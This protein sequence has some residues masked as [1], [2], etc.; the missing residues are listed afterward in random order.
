MA[1]DGPETGMQRRLAEMD[2]RLR[3]I[4]AELSRDVGTPER[5][6]PGTRPRR[7]QRAPRI[8]PPQHPVDPPVDPATAT[9]TPPP[10]ESEPGTGAEPSE[11]ATGVPAPGGDAARAARLEAMCARLMRATQELLSGYELAL[12]HVSGG[13]EGSAVTLA[14]GPFSGVA[15]LE[16]FQATLRRLPD[17]AGVT[18]RGY[19]GSDRAILEVQLRG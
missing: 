1:Q 9:A 11:Q 13:A 19:E 5:A 8:F 15:A 10:R 16:H 6:A 12:G 17:V 18:V 2:E 3:T 7:S 4:Q 14:A